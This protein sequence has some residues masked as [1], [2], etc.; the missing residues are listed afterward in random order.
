MSFFE[1]PKFPPE[2]GAWLVG[3]RGFQTIITDTFGGY[4]Y[5]NSAWA[6]ARGVWDIGEALRTVGDTSKLPMLNLYKLLL[7]ARGRLHTFRVYAPLDNNDGSG[8]ILGLTGLATSATVYQM[9]KNVILSGATTYQ[10]IVRTP[11]VSGAY[12]GQS[13]VKIFDNA[14]ERTANFSID[15][16]T[17]EVTFTSPFPVVG[18]ALTWTGSHDIPV[19]FHAD[20]PMIGLDPSGAL[21]TWQGIKLVEI[22]NP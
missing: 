16:K 2:I 1:T 14:V 3:G 5:R 17:G 8:G 6:M 4:E 13:N 15:T 20:F 19:R 7:T 12:S 18:H 22:R 11:I 21:M 10:Q 9:Y